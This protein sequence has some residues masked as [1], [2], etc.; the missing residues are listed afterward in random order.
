MRVAGLGF[1]QEATHTALA[2][3]LA[4]ARA[5]TGDRPVSAIATHENKSK[6]P[7]IQALAAELE[8]PVLPIRATALAET[9]TE[10]QSDRI[11]ALYGTGSIAEAAALAAA[12]PGARLVCARVISEDGMA[13]AAI[14]EG[15]M[16]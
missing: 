8:L 7:A 6:H 3:A 12:G 15:Q 11:A 9:Q 10:T 2:D 13:V 1:R 16:A 14:A 4:K 5:I